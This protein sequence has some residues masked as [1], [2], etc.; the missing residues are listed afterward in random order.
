MPK[1]IVDTSQF[2]YKDMFGR[3]IKVGDYIVYGAVD[4]RSGTLRAGQVVE[5]TYSKSDYGDP[6]PKIT[7]KSWSNFRS[8][9]SW[10]SPKGKETGRQKNVSLGF[11]DRLIVVPAE[12]VGEQVKKDLDGPYWTY[13][14]KEDERRWIEHH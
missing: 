12:T 4:G 2:E 3:D 9:D 1:K 13:D 14:W 8:R 6:S 11:L 5:L 7:A 10:N